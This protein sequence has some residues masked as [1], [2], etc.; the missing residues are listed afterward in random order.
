M[1]PAPAGEAQEE[2]FCPYTLGPDRGVHRGRRACRQQGQ[3]LQ[4]PPPEVSGTCAWLV[5]AQSRGDAG[6]RWGSGYRGALQGPG[7]KRGSG[8]SPAV[9]DDYFH[10]PC[11]NPSL[12]CKESH[13]C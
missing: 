12:T 9:P 1:S 10:A 2:P 3:L 11:I 13:S 5:G 4:H 8:P 6:S 7:L